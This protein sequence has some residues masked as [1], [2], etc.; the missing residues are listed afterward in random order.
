MAQ[1]LSRGA[2]QTIELLVTQR[3]LRRAVDAD[4]LNRADTVVVDS[5]AALD[6]DP[7]PHVVG[8]GPKHLVLVH[9]EHR[10]HLSGH[11]TAQ[12]GG[13]QAQHAGWGGQAGDAVGA[14][15]EGNGQGVPPGQT[16]QRGLDGSRRR[17]GVGVERDQSRR[18]VAGTHAQTELLAALAADREHAR[19]RLRGGCYASGAAAVELQGGHRCAEVGH[20][21][22]T[23]GVIE[24]HAHRHGVEQVAQ[25]GGDG[26]GRGAGVHAVGQHARVDG[27]FGRAVVAQRD[28]GATGAGREVGALVELPRQGGGDRRQRL[29]RRVPN[30]VADDGGT[31][32]V[33]D[34]PDR[35]G[36]D[37]LGAEQ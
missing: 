8:A 6:L 1:R 12:A 23:V 27:C 9:A 2:E 29:G 28:H 15:T 30:R 13:I 16:P 36:L 10:G 21:V 32:G 25:R 22:A 14:A 34:L 11:S 19:R 4:G 37:V 18:L 7:V 5:G 17:G 33:D 35:T 20:H 24:A 31:G 26:V 3:G